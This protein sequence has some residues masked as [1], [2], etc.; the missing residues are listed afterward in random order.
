MSQTISDAE[1]RE[2]LWKLIAEFDT[3]MLVTRGPDGGLRSRP[4]A[5]AKKG[6]ELGDDALYFST[7]IESGK[8]AD[9]KADEQVNVSMQETRRF[10]SLTGT[11]R[12]TRDRALIDK[13]WAEG[14]KIWFPNGKDDPSLS[15]LMVE[16]HEASYWDISGGTGLKY[17]F[18]SAKAYV[19]GTRP[20]SD[21]DER[22]TAHVK[23]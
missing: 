15:I 9:L 1:K 17:L 16:P 2:R 23:L 4:L 7:S 20:P 8:V 6:Q 3:A 14:W 12:V 5:I 13:L 22:H 11:A 21:D 19:S 18:E 10:V